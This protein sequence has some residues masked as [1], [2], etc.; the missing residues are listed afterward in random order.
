[1]EVSAR[2][3]KLTLVEALTTSVDIMLN[4]FSMWTGFWP[5]VEGSTTITIVTASFVEPEKLALVIPFWTNTTLPISS[6]VSGS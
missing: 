6:L 4:G 1:M 3:N 5:M 2:K